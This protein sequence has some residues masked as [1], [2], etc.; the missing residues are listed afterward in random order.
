MASTFR[1]SAVFG[2]VLF[3]LLQCSLG[4]RKLTALVEQQPL[5]LTYHQGHL[6]SGPISVNLIWYGKFTPVQRAIVADFFASVASSS[7]RRSAA[8]AAQQQPSVATW[9]KTTER[10]YALSKPNPQH[11]Q[12]V[13]LAARG[14]QRRAVNVVLTADDVAVEGFCM[15]RCGTHGASPRSK[16]GRFT[17][18]WVGNSANP[19]LVAPNGDVGVD[20]MVI[21]LGSLLSATFT[22]P[23]GDG[24]FQGPPEA[25]LEAASA[26][27]GIYGKNAYPGYAGD[28]LVDPTTGASYNAN[29]LNG[30][31]YLLPALVDPATSACS[32]VV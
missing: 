27:P 19:P 31:K 6:L 1:V 12:L 23:F 9:W 17:Y 20:G 10:Y 14:G 8:T 26:C 29:G 25:P 24:F 11:P 2:L 7:S 30:R 16:N 13:A 21:N 22:N 18:I 28:L 5:T 4:A 15:S 3:S 32:T